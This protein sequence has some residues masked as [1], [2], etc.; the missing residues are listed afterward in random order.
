[1]APQGHFTSILPKPAA[2]VA[3][4]FLTLFTNS[5]SNRV[6][7]AAV[8]RGVPGMLRLSHGLYQS[9]KRRVPPG[10]GAFMDETALNLR[11]VRLEQ[12]D[13]LCQL[14]PRKRCH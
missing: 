5:T 10:V 1:M 9:H 8:W 13:D 7:C 4:R 12:N 2:I 11:I 3:S 6:S 14:K